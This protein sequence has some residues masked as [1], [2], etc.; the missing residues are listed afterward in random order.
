MSSESKGSSDQSRDHFD[1]VRNE[2]S[3]NHTLK[4]NRDSTIKREI[5]HNREDF[6][7]YS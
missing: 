7:R 6:L 3:E 4:I 2:D 1:S 5:N